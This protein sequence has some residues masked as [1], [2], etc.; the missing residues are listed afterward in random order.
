MQCVCN[1][2][3]EGRCSFPGYNKAK[4]MN[5]GCSVLGVQTLNYNFFHFEATNKMKEEIIRSFGSLKV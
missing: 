3:I 5:L 2:G 4:F 1:S